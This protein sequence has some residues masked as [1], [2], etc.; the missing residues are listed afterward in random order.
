ERYVPAGRLLDV[1]CGHGLLLDEAR[2]RG[3]ETTG[4]ELS[5]AAAAYARDVLQL[6]VREETLDELADEG[7]RYA[8]IVL[9]D[10]LEHLDD[11]QAAL[12]RCFELL[13]PGGVLC[14]ATPDPSSL[15]ARVAGPRWWAYIPAHTYLFPRRTLHELIAARGLVISDDVPLVRTFS[16]RYWLFGLAERSGRLSAAAGALARIL[17]GR[18]RLSLSLGDERVVL[19]HKVE[20]IAPQKPLVRDRGGERKVHVVLPAYNASATIPLV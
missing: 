4:I 2:R 1:G 20:P 14:V 12:D 11:P 7:E 15:T 5:A 17:P 19:A 10:V 18:L 3:Y 16:I 9:V 6:D 13:A 8:A